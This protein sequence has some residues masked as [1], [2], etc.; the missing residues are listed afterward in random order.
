MK[1]IKVRAWDEETETMFYSDKEYDDCFFEFKD[2]RLW[3]FAIREPKS[4]NDPMEPP[5]P[6]TDCYEPMQ[7]TDLLDK[8]GKEIYESDVVRFHHFTQVLGEKLGV[9]EDEEEFNAVVDFGSAGIMLNDEPMFMYNGT[10]E[11]SLE[12]VGNKFENPELSK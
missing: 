6:Y 7:F 10:H 12:I 9:T 3:G 5:E 1:T 4:S 8:N 11:E 2:G